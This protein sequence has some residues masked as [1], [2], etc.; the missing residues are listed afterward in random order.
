[1]LEEYNPSQA[2]YIEHLSYLVGCK[3]TT[4]DPRQNCPGREAQREFE[5]AFS[6]MK[7]A[8][9]AAETRLGRRFWR[10]E[11]DVDGRLSLVIGTHPTKK[12]DIALLVH[13]DVVDAPEEMFTL[14][15]DPRQK[16]LVIGRG[17]YD[18][19]FAAAMT[20]LLLGHLPMVT[21]NLSVAIIITS[22]EEKGGTRGAKHI[23]EQGYSP[24]FLIVPDGGA[25]DR[26]ASG[27]K[28][29][30]FFEIKTRGLATHG[31]Y[32]WRGVNADN[33]MTRIKARLLD[34]YPESSNHTENE[35]LTI[36]AS[37]AG[38]DAPN[39]V[40]EMATALFDFRFT[41]IEEEIRLKEHV[42]TILRDTIAVTLQ[43]RPWILLLKEEERPSATYTFITRADAVLRAMNHPDI[44]RFKHLREKRLGQTIKVG[45]DI[46]TNDARFWP[47]V[48]AILTMPVGGNEHTTR[49]WLDLESLHGFAKDIVQ[50]IQEKN[51]ESVAS[52]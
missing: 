29:A 44:Q 43:A 31:A 47:K 3:T 11:F 40:P 18:M 50:F 30:H 28:G 36:G 12:P 13:M 32:P 35:T 39:N 49:E 5:R 19:K 22:D 24:K 46:G 6:Y 10:E 51:Q 20:I 37:R 26:F 14:R 27:S 16:K 23:S 45:I 42:D 38:G 52:R 34:I 1:M 41:T 21:D 48:P 9:L 2:E 8:I 33:M 15:T 7:N 17:V 25:C 4:V